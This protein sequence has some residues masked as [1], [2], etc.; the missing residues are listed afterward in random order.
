VLPSLISIALVPL[1]IFGPTSSTPSE[2]LYITTLVQILTQLLSIPLLPNRLPL[3]SLTL[4]SKSIPYTAFPHVLPLVVSKLKEINVLHRVHILANLLAF[5]PPRYTVLPARSM[6]AYLALLAELL[7]GVAP[8][9]FEPESKQK[10]ALETATWIVDSDDE[11]APIRVERVTTFANTPAP[12]PLPPL[13]AKTLARLAILPSAPHMRSL[14]TVA[15]GDGRPALATLILALNAA[16]PARKTRVLSSVL[17]H[18]GGSLLRELYRGWVRGSPVGRDESGNA[19]F[20]KSMSAKIQ[21]IYSLASVDEKTATVWPPLLL[22]VELYTHALLTMHDDEFFSSDHRH[23]HGSSAF[24]LS[25]ATAPAAAG[26]TSDA[27]A[28]ARNPLS[29]DELTGLSRQLLNIVFPL[30]WRDDAGEAG[31][32]MAAAPVPGVPGLSW[33]G[34]RERITACLQ[35]IHLRE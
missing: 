20:G 35:A 11:D 18:A 1:T 29:L 8:N 7:S 32:R 22:L 9:A 14:V 25:A 5:V 6:T 4:L 34:A 12:V 26:A 16:W 13:D 2:T 19:L 24:T 3:P 23:G 15:K 17:A 30:Y 31:A 28:A 27:A 21:N 10:V 33:V